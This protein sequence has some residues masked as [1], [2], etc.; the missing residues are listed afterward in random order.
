MDTG[1]SKSRVLGKATAHVHSLHRL[2]G[3]AL[4]EVFH[5]SHHRHAIAPPLTASDT[6]DSESRNAIIIR[7]LRHDR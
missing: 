4:H 7:V 6:D 5:C 2:A 3:R 1:E